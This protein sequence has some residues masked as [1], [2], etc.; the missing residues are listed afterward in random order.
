[1]LKHDLRLMLLATALAGGA[2]AP[3]EKPAADPPGNELTTD[4]K[5]P[6]ARAGD[7]AVE[8][9]APG[10]IQ[11]QQTA[12]IPTGLREVRALA[13][14]PQDRIYVGGDKAVRIFE[15]N[16]TRQGEIALDA[17][18]RCLAVGTTEGSAAEHI[19]VGMEKHGE[20]WDGK[21]RRIAAWKPPAEKGLFTSIAVAEQDVFVA[22]YA[23]QIVWHY[24]RT[25]TLK[26]RIGARDKARNIPGL[27]ATTPYLDLA[28]GPDGL[29]YVVNPRLLRLEAY[30]FGGDLES[31]WGAGS[32]SIDGFFG[33]CNPIH[34][35][36]GPDGRFATA[37][38]G[39]HRIKMYGRDGKFECVV[40]GPRQMAAQAADLAVDSRGR[41]LA[42]DPTTAAVRV[43]ERKKP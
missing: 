40:A 12:E 27:L 8:E 34:F 29:L 2:C 30:T 4:S 42:L 37:E 31:Q 35:A 38:K 23:N 17:Q 22:D 43:F 19:Y 20:V 39:I 9:I 3:R 18:P 14:G 5:S 33:C 16:G 7:P 15:P 10:L 32:S 26:G 21:G 28:V 41:V 13:L 24:D 1:M 36:I 6:E 11:Y 25:G